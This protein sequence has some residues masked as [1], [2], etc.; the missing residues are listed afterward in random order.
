MFES[1]A[2]K[3]SGFLG[4]GASMGTF[5]AGLFVLTLSSRV[6]HNDERGNEQTVTVGAIKFSWDTTRA[7]LRTRTTTML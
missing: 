6:A 1:Q 5:S 7:K 4:N 2:E 3:K